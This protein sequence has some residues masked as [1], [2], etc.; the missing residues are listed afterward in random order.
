MFLST[1]VDQLFIGVIG[2]VV[3]NVVTV[4]VVIVIVVIAVVI[5]VVVRG[6]L[7]RAA[8]FFQLGGGSVQAE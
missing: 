4:T 7:G 8:H 5:V 6:T 1:T 3:V 2:I